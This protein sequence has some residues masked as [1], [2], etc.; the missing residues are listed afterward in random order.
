MS[1]LMKWTSQQLRKNATK[2]ENRLWYNYLRAYPVQFRRQVVF[3][4]FIVDFYC[5]KA[6]LVLELDGSQHYE[7]N[8]PEYDAERTNCLVRGTVS[9]QL[10]Q[11]LYL[12][13][14]F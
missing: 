2:E 14:E 3:G 13:V 5:A 8:G 4:R 6:K 11:D 12:L 7:G 10:A 9:G 1:Q